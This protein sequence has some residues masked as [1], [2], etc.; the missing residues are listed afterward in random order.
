MTTFE[1]DKMCKCGGTPARAVQRLRS[2]RLT[3]G[4]A[5]LLVGQRGHGKPL[6]LSSRRRVPVAEH[7]GQI[8]RPNFAIIADVW[9]ADL[10]VILRHTGF[11]ASGGFSF[12]CMGRRKWS[13]RTGQQREIEGVH[14]A[15]A[16]QVADGGWG[17][18]WT[19]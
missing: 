6:T 13:P 16:V 2:A 11:R 15:V 17:T 10:H 9:S 18:L 7:Y 19:V 4:F 5:M 8:E 14:C 1:C 3:P 12:R